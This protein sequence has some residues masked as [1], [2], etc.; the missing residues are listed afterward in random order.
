MKQLEK[1][2]IDFIKEIEKEFPED[3]YEYLYFIKDRFLQEKSINS[4]KEEGSE[5]CTHTS[6]MCMNH[7][8]SNYTFCDGINTECKFYEPQK[9]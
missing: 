6:S 2:L 8:E 9:D 1:E 7:E 3:N 5:I 4:G